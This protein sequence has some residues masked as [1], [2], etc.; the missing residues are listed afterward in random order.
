MNLEG[1]MMNFRMKDQ[2]DKASYLEEKNEL[3][4]SIRIQEEEKIK[5]VAEARIAK[6]QSELTQKQARVMICLQNKVR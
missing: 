2:A 1:K 5:H 3:Q 4:L 6:R